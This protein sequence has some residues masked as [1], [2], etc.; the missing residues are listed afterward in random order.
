MEGAADW[1]LQNVGHV[2]NS[3]TIQP[4]VSTRPRLPPNVLGR[5]P[6]IAPP[7]HGTLHSPATQHGPQDA[8]PG[9]TADIVCGGLEASPRSRIE[10][11]DTPALAP[12]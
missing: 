11:K 10:G 8:L 3:D 4:F 9:T 6:A 7:G 2:I 5:R 1:P 12:S